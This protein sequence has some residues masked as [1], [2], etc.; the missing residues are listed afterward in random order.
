[1]KVAHEVVMKMHLHTVVADVLVAGTNPM[2][3]VVESL[4]IEKNDR[5][6]P[7]KYGTK[8][9]DDVEFYLYDDVEFYEKVRSAKLVRDVEEHRDR[10]YQQELWQE[11][12]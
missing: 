8:L 10:A 9:Y 11:E 1:M 3:F 7:I 2:D 12:V 5:R 6:Y 4:E